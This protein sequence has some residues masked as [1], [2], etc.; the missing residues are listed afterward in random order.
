MTVT[1]TGVFNRAAILHPE[2]SFAICCPSK[3]LL[4]SGGAHPCDP[5]STPLPSDKDARGGRTYFSAMEY[6]LLPDS[7]FRTR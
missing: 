1:D 3:C 2:Q 5:D 7:L 4:C 6:L